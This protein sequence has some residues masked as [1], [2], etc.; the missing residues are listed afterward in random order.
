M[1]KT[2][3]RFAHLTQVFSISLFNRRCRGAIVRLPFSGSARGGAA[4][5]ARGMGRGA[6][7]SR[8]APDS[9]APGSGVMV[10]SRFGPLSTPCSPRCMRCRPVDFPRI[11]RH[12]RRATVA[13]VVGNWRSSPAVGLSTGG[14]TVFQW[15]V[16]DYAV[17]V[18][19][20]DHPPDLPD[21]NLPSHQTHI[22]ISPIHES[23]AP[24]S[25][26]PPIPRAIRELSGT[27]FARGSR[28]ELLATLFDGLSRDR[29]CYTRSPYMIEVPVG[30]G[31]RASVHSRAPHS[32]R[33]PIPF[34]AGSLRQPRT[35]GLPIGRELSITEN[36]ASPVGASSRSSS[37]PATSLTAASIADA[38]RLLHASS[39]PTHRDRRAGNAD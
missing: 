5:I 25:R 13:V 3:R 12:R 6:M 30:R 33:W 28:A 27:A 22:T 24:L 19:S 36:M 16:G 38:L 10:S 4:A 7:F 37:Q 39:V 20:R 32:R 18:F 26:L 15:G 34:R 11:S 29:C 14:A 17:F 2:A 8:D 31:D 35:G 23:Y 21:G 9:P 1:L